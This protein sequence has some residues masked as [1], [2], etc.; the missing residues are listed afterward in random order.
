MVHQNDRIT[1]GDQILHHCIQPDD[2]GRMQTDRG[3]VQHV[4]HAGGPVPDGSGQLHPLTLS[5]RQRRSR[6]IQGQVRKSQIHQTPCRAP[7]GLADAFGHGAH[8][9]WQ[10]C[11][12][13]V[14]PVR[15]LPKGHPT[16][17]L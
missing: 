15:Q 5:G 7:E 10:R 13:T 17:R 14:H 16:G 4:E 3:L 8:L 1:V 11:R 9:F 12:H 6:P 2:I